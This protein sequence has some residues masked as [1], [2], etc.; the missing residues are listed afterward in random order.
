MLGIFVLNLQGMQGGIY[1]MLNHGLSTGALFL[2]VGMIYERRH[3]KLIAEFGGVSK[4]MPIFAAFF[5][6][7]TLS[8]IGLPLLNGFVGEFLI[9]L[10]VFK[11]NYIYCALGATGMI[12]GAVYMLWAYQRVM[13]GPLDK[14]ENKALIDLSLREIMVLLPIAIMFFVMGIYPKPF[15]SRMEPTV[16]EL[17]KTKFHEQTAVTGIVQPLIREK[18]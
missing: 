14:P 9:L 1:Q 6:L 11:W 16:K 3:T 5:M 17:L 10:G 7:A 18:H 12:L 4:V 15:L 13:F 2:I 8:S